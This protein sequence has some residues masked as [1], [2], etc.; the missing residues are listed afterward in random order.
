MGDPRKLAI[1]MPLAT[2]EE[3]AQIGK[4]F[5]DELHLPGIFDINGNLVPSAVVQHMVH[6]QKAEFEKSGKWPQEAKE[7][8]G[9]YK[10]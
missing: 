3:L 10:L 4:L 9:A 2:Q 5:N 1:Y 8:N 7:E 6:L